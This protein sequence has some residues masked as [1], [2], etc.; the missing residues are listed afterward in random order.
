[1]KKIFS[2][3][4]LFLA[5]LLLAFQL[6][7]LPT[8]ASALTNNDV[9]PPSN[10]SYQLT[11][12]SDIKLTWSSVNGAASYNVYRIVDG[13]LILVDN[14]KAPSYTFN[15][16]EEGSYDYVVSTISSY[17]ESAPSVLVN[18]NIVYPDMIAPT[19]LTSKVQNGNDLLLSWT[20]STYAK[21]YNIYKTSPTG[22]KTLVTSLSA[23]TYSTTN[24]PEG[25]Y[26]YE[27]SAV[28]P[29]YGESPLSNPLDV[30][31]VWPTMGTPNNLTYSLLNVNDIALKWDS[32]PY[33]TSYK[34]YQIVNGEKI[35]KSTVTNTSVGYA[36]MPTDNYVYEVH[37]YNDRFGDASSKQLYL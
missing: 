35:L 14:T 25:S 5:S 19:A 15:N 34:I 33:A 6:A 28:N 31:I 13:T 22:D 8:N 24:V 1:M 17:G 12:P 32:V 37:S 23:T 16:V 2:S 9:L 20:A 27:V 10:L 7:F 26:T 18:V 36:N 29:L 4:F 11:T 30:D 3:S 21:S